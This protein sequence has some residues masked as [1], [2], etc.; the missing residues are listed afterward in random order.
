MD[1]QPSEQQNNF[2]P[3]AVVGQPNQSIKKGGIKFGLSIVIVVILII[4]TAVA[5]YWIKTDRQN[6]FC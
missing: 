6:N 3:S 5:V 4:A 2:T 1:T